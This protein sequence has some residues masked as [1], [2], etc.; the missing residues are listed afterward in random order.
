MRTKPNTEADVNKRR[1]WDNLILEERIE[2]GFAARKNRG[3]FSGSSIHE[4]VSEYIVGLVDNT[5]D[6]RE[7][8]ISRRFQVTGKEQLFSCSPSCGTTQGQMA[9][10]PVQGKTDIDVNCSKC[11]KIQIARVLRKS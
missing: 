11:R 4:V 1:K 8:T 7:G 9:A 2:F 5:I 3:K 6:Q 10:L